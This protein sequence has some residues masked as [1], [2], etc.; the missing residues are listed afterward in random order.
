MRTLLTGCAAEAVAAA[1]DPL[2]TPPAKPFRHGRRPKG[3]PYYKTE[4]THNPPAAFGKPMLKHSLTRRGIT[5]RYDDFGFLYGVPKVV[6]EEL[7]DLGLGNAD[8]SGKAWRFAKCGELELRQGAS[9][10]PAP[11][12]G[13]VGAAGAA[14]GPVARPRAGAAGG[15]VEVRLLAAACVDCG[16]VLP[17]DAKMKV[18]PENKVLLPNLIGW[19]GPAGPPSSVLIHAWTLYRPQPSLVV[20]VLDLISGS[21]A[22]AAEAEGRVEK[23]GSWMA[24]RREHAG[25]AKPMS[26]GR[27]E[28]SKAAVPA[29][30]VKAAPGGK[31]LAGG[32]SEAQLGQG[33]DGGKAGGAKGASGSEAAAVA[34][35]A[36]TKANSTPAIA[37]AAATDPSAAAGTGTP[38]RQAQP[39]AAGAAKTAL[40]LGNQV[41][42]P[43]R[44]PRGRSVSP[45]QLVVTCWCASTGCAHVSDTQLV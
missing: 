8:A 26:G 14:G 37:G 24:S 33:G 11:A 43:P 38:S 45:W 30:G 21:R 15:S 28:A 42:W 5:I 29:A 44:S 41:R 25:A 9:F 4:P 32:K 34:T 40:P 22:A 3:L 1:T 31:G 12:A 19:L 17:I 7:F 36:A 10:V 35:G 2:A 16:D 20:L 18:G 23:D 13:T 6:A 27:M 39:T